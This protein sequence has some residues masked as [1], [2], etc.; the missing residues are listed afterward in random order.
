MGRYCVRYK[1]IW[2][3]VPD[4][5]TLDVPNKFGSAIIWPICSSPEHISGADACNDGDSIL[6]FIR[7]FIAGA[8]T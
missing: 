1:G 2:W 8:G 7:C 3:L 5:A 6:Y 4:S